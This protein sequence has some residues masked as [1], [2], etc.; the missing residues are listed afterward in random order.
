MLKTFFLK[1]AENTFLNLFS[2]FVL[3]LATGYLKFGRA[4]AL[5]GLTWALAIEVAVILVAAHIS[6]RIRRWMY[7]KPSRG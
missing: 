1:A 4:Q 5:S 3:G 2:T 7:R 6:D